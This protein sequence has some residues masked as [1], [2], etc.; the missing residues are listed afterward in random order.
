MS[1]CN[2]VAR[3]GGQV[4]G[5]KTAVLIPPL[6]RSW[7]EMN[8]S[9]AASAGD[10]VSATGRTGDE[11]LAEILMEE[12]E[13]HHVEEEQFELGR[14]FDAWAVRT[15]SS[16]AG[17][18]GFC[19]NAAPSSAPTKESPTTESPLNTTALPNTTSPT[20]EAITTTAGPQKAV[21]SPRRKSPNE[22]EKKPWCEDP[23]ITAAAGGGV[24]FLFFVGLCCG[25]CLSRRK[26]EQEEEARRKT[27]TERE[28]DLRRGFDPDFGR[29]AW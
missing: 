19:K 29:I 9:T 12:V 15:S 8:R 7:S 20:A 2:N 10:A 3:A 14:A 4:P 17:G 24:V 28:A 25:I 5:R 13:A 26:E 21:K 23:M 6:R 1:N 11:I 22:K 18:N 27:E 16:S